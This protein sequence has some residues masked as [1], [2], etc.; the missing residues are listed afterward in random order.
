[1][2]TAFKPGVQNGRSKPVG[3]AEA[4]ATSYSTSSAK[5]YQLQDPNAWPTHSNDIMQSAISSAW[6]FCFQS[7]STISLQLMTAIE[8][9]DPSHL[10]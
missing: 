1:M 10:V 5:Y 4:P 6:T 2:A 9:G 8:L 7:L 3:D